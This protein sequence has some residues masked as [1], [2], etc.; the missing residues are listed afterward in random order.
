MSG[1]KTDRDERDRFRQRAEYGNFDG[2][3]AE[4]LLLLDDLEEALK[5]IE[6]VCDFGS[7]ADH[8]SSEDGIE[9]LHGHEFSAKWGIMSEEQVLAR[10]RAVLPVKVPSA[11][12][13]D[14]KCFDCRDGKHCYGN[15]SGCPC[16]STC[17]KR[18]V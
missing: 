10:L 1:L 8:D 6:C 5:A 7:L 9:G 12:P 11:L 3:D 16:R 18:K 13:T 14:D 4:V 17:G 15:T 2:G